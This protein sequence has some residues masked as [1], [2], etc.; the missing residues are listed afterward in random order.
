M[1]S[2][3]QKWECIQKINPVMA[4][5]HYR[6]SNETPISIAINTFLEGIIEDTLV[7]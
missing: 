2:K 6:T 1:L 5:G 3:T 7:Y 4:I